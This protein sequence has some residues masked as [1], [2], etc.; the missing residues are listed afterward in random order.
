MNLP[1]KLTLLRIVL[2][3]PFIAFLLLS[4]N[5]SM[6]F[7]LLAFAVFMAASITDFLDGYIARKYN[8]I[9]DFG[10]LMDPLA[11]KI[12][13]LGALILFVELHYIPSW[14]VIIII[15]R[16]FLVSGVR[17]LAASKGEVI[18]AGMSG[19]LKTTTQMIA[20]L[21]IIFTGASKVSLYLMLIPVFL[22]IYSGYE[23]IMKA[24]HY[25]A[26]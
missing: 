19:K 9:S 25:F 6:F 26:E 23:I 4:G 18:P 12:L 17:S 22:T 8:L 3:I 5:G 20:I 13:V 10:K 7:K 16:E 11:D 2:I 21:I 24:K 15:F 1:N 14:M